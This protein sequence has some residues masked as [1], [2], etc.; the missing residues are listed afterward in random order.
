MVMLLAL[1]VGGCAGSPVSMPSPP[2]PEVASQPG[3]T[4][5]LTWDAPADLDLYLTDP[6]A[7]TIYF[8]NTPSRTG[9][10][11]IRDTRCSDVRATRAPYI[12]VVHV[13]EP[14]PGGYRVGVDFIERCG[15]ETTPVA[16]RTVVQLDGSRRETV[17]TIQLEEFQPIVVEFELPPG[18][19]GALPTLS[20][21]DR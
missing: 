14:A 2:L 8:A 17:G 9:G 1:A 3:L 21:E 12:E 18:V 7:E 5:M 15:R 10:S 4:V 19:N 13:P 16:F 6:T 20:G 11:L